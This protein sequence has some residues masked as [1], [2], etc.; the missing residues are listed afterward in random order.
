MPTDAKPQAARDARAIRNLDAPRTP[1]V[2]APA[3]PLEH[4]KALGFQLRVAWEALRAALQQRLDRHGVRFAHWSYLRVLWVSDG[5]TQNELSER[6][7]RV[8][9]NTV[10]A[11]NAMERAGLVRRVRSK[12]D[13]RT[14]HVHLTP[15]GRALERKLVPLAAEAQDRALAGVAAAD[16]ETLERVLAAMRANLG[17]P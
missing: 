5:I 12:A 13:R 3:T 6:V 9:A 14:I 16:I 8:G 11:L 1:R 15:A 17:G 4:E 7:R 2:V 10:S